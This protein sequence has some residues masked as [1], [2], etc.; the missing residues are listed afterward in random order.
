M[1]LSFEFYSGKPRSAIDETRTGAACILEQKGL[2]RSAPALWRARFR[3]GRDEGLS[4]VR[5]FRQRRDYARKVYEK[6]CEK[7]LMKLAD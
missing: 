7:V 1:T 5:F 4:D 3:W 2:R 6:G